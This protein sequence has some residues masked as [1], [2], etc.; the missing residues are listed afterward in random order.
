MFNFKSSTRLAFS[1][2][3]VGAAI[4]WLTIELGVLPN[5]AT[6][7]IRERLEVA[8][9]IVVELEDAIE[10][11]RLHKI[12]GFLEQIVANNDDLI[13]VGLVRNDGCCAVA[14]ETHEIKWKSDDFSD[15]NR[16]SVNIQQLDRTWGTLQVLYDPSNP[17]VNPAI[18]Y[19]FGPVLFLFGCLSA[20]S[21]L[22]LTQTFRYLN[23]SKIIPHRVRSALDTL[24]EGLVLIDPHGEIVHSNVAFS[25][26]VETASEDLFGSKLSQFR[27]ATEGADQ[28]EGAT[29]WLD[30]LESRESIRGRI[31]ELTN[32][33]SSKKYIVNSSPVFSGGDKIKGALI[34]FDDVTDLERK[35][36]ELAD[37]ISTLRKSRDEVA[38]QNEELY[39]LANCDP[40]TKCFNRRS[41]WNQY[42]EMWNQCDQG[43]L[44]LVMVDIDHFKS[45]NDNYGHS[46]GDEVLQQSGELLRR[47]TG[48]LGSV[49]RYGGEEFIVLLP[50]MSFDEATEV[51]KRIHKEYQANQLGGISVTASLGVSNTEFGVM[52]MQHLLDQADQCLYTAKR[53]GRNQVVRYDQCSQEFDRP[54]DGDANGPTVNI[55]YSTVTGLLSALAFKCSKT[56]EHSVRV[57][58]LCVAIGQQLIG[59][60]DLYRLEVC[61][62]LHDIGKI[63]VPE[64]ILNKPGPLTDREWE[65]MRMHDEYGVSIVRSA[66]ESDEMAEIIR[67]HKEN[68]TYHSTP[69][70]LG[71]CE[72]PL[73]S[74]IITA[75]DAFDSMIGDRV[76][77]QAQPLEV[78]INELLRCTPDQFDPIVVEHLVK[79]AM[80]PG[81]MQS[82]QIAVK[83][84][85]QAAVS[86]AKYLEEFH[87]AVASENL[88]DLKEAV[89]GLKEEAHSVDI[90]VIADAADR[91]ETIIET[92][93]SKLSQVMEIAEEVMQLCRSTRTSIVAQDLQSLPKPPLS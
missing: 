18:S 56:A 20:T 57:A 77:R 53:N 15:G 22:I 25:E 16:A 32:N 69:G 59:K 88:R 71:K 3:I 41:F 64:N 81:F 35:K 29:P 51:A 43:K 54:D 28:R 5:P 44:N 49:C 78:A 86:I 27:W 89:E 92:G 58:D 90:G 36:T 87:A 26:M 66:F 72:I 39:F 62:L 17:E 73:E 37:I 31:L 74:K 24:T 93:D 85:P 10:Q 1:V 13:S 76:Y 6:L 2:G 82:R 12:N 14:T 45:I 19:P 80:Q 23:P 61:G 11:N 75:C 47:I 4:L 79:Y 70:L 38:R 91:L 84:S 40:L 46:T 42:T 67:Y 48:D 34:S 7:K 21:W 30:C 63:G 83:T 33:G 55:K 60:K 68:D 8:K 50:N 65:M 52:D 9:V